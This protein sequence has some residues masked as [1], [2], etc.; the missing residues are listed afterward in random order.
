MPT[1]MVN[2]KMLLEKKANLESLLDVINPNGRSLE[3]DV[4]DLMVNSIMDYNKKVKKEISEINKELDLEQSVLPLIKKYGHTPAYIFLLNFDPHD[5]SH[6]K[7]AF[8][9]IHKRECISRHISDE[10]VVPEI[11]KISYEDGAVLLDK[12]GFIYATN[13]KLEDVNPSAIINSNDEEITKELFGFHRGEVGKR[14]YSSIG[15]SFHMKGTV[16]YTLGEEGHITRFE[17][18]KIIFS[19]VDEENSVN[20][21]DSY[22]DTSRDHAKQ[23]APHASGIMNSYGGREFLVINS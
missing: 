12:K 21:R 13:I 11:M 5:E 23:K 14:H 9:G 6:K 20:I 8:D 17:N 19:T 2:T 18:G 16:V 15:A 4:Y 3:L 10:S 22:R 7:H 1:L